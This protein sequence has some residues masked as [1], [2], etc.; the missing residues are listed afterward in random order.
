MKRIFNAIAS[1]LPT[2]PTELAEPLVAAFC[3][4]EA[5]CPA[6]ILV[7]QL[8]NAMFEVMHSDT[9]GFQATHEV[10][11]LLADAYNEADRIA[12]QQAKAKAAQ[13]RLEA[14]RSLFRLDARAHVSI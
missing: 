13:R 6:K 9:L 7:V 4:V 1:A 12:H 8:D 5:G 14:Q 10:L 2:L 3:K 11:D